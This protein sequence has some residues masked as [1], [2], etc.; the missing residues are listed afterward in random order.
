MTVYIDPPIWPGHGRMWSHLVSDASY[1][2]LHAFAARI[3]CP[4]RAFDR[5]HYDI[6]STQYDVA[7]RAGAVEVGSKELLHHLKA[8]GLRRRKR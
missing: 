4:P 2:E 7:V 6:P 3:G 8:A 5:D 1:E